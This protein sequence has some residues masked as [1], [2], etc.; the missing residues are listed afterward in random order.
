MKKLLSVF[1]A[2]AVLFGFA[3]CSGDMHDSVVSSLYAEG[4]FC[5]KDGDTTVRVKFDMTPGSDTEQT[6][7]FKYDSKMTAWGGSNGTV[8]FKIV[9]DE[10]GWLKDWGWLKDTKVELS[11]NST[12]W[13]D[14]EGR[15]G[16]NDNPGN[17]VLKDLVVG[18]SYKLILKYD[19]PAEKVS[20]KCTGAVTDYP[21]LKAHIVDA[22]D[23]KELTDALADDNS[24]VILVRSGTSYS[25]EIFVP[26]KDGKIEYYLTNGYLYWGADGEMSTTKPTDDYFVGEWKFDENNADFPYSFFVDANNFADSAKFNSDVRIYDTSILS[27]ADI[28]GL[29]G[30]WGNGK[31]LSFIDGVSYTYDFTAGGETE[32]FV[33][34]EKAGSWDTRWFGGIPEGKGKPATP[35]LMDD[36]EVGGAAKSAVYYDK[37]PGLDGKNIVIKGLSKDSI[38]TIVIQIK[39]ASKKEIAVSCKLKQAVEAQMPNITDYWLHSNVY[40]S[41]WDKDANG[42]YPKFVATANPNEYTCEFKPYSDSLEFGLSKGDAFGWVAGCG[43]VINALDTTVNGSVSSGGNSKITGLTAGSSYILT[44]KVLDVDGNATAKVSL[45]A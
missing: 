19:A 3:S 28:I 13:L 26:T 23:G 43:F 25:S 37:D 38:Y 10:T 1:A 9:R 6:Y 35:T 17:I 39:D 41:S 11:V 16:S 34:R 18:N 21:I 14:L 15:G 27:N 29:N 44:I 8:N 24:D 42:E 45:K 32:S 12:E 40:S 31:K 7:V 33:I 36:V 22:A 4:D 5:E 20:I 2:A 30:D